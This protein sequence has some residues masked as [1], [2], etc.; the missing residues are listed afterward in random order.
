MMT[1]G[2]N[3]RYT[4]RRVYDV[5]LDCIFLSLVADPLVSLPLCCYTGI[6]HDVTRGSGMRLIS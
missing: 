6:K 2:S 5:Y 4:G 1:V 3:A